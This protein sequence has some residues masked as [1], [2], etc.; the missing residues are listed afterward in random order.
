MLPKL[1]LVAICLIPLAILLPQIHLQRRKLRRT[2]KSPFTDLLLRPAGESLR[3]K[4]GELDEKLNDHL[5]SALAYPLMVAAFLFLT[6]PHQERPIPFLIV[7]VP[8]VSVFIGG[9]YFIWGRKI[10]KLW[11]EIRDH[12]LGFQGERYVGEEL[13]QLLKEGFRVFH[14]LE[15]DRFNIDHVLVGPPGVFAVETKTRRKPIGEKGKAAH[16]VIFDGGKLHYPWGQD[17]HGLKQAKR[18]ADHLATWLSS[19][20]GEKVNVEA[21]LTLPGWWVERTGRGTVHVVNTKEIPKIFPRNPPSPLSPEQIQR[22]AHQIEQ[23]C[24]N[25]EV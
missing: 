12:E 10:P 16:K 17:T 4:I 22:I 21:I 5:L 13:N 15:F 9:T 7:C 23:K 3:L 24:R 11:M 6:I 19:A 20:T 18:N 8:I 1:I 14:D 2:V 25:L